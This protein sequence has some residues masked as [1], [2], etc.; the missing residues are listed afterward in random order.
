MA[1]PAA[2]A[3]STAELVAVARTGLWGDADAVRAAEEAIAVLAARIDQLEAEVERARA[4]YG[5]VVA[6]P[7]LELRMKLMRGE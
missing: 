5:E 7:L 6:D 4:R 1:L 2:P 3:E